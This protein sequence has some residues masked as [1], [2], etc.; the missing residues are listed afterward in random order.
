[1]KRLVLALIPVLLLAQT[2]TEKLHKIFDEEHAE[3]LRENPQLAASMY[4]RQ[5]GPGRWNDQS[6]EARD[7]RREQSRA[8]LGALRALNP[9][10]LSRADRFNY[11]LLVNRLQEQVDF[12]A[13]P[14][15]LLALT[16]RFASP[17]YYLPRALNDSPSETVDDYKKILD[18]LRGIPARLDQQTALLQRGVQEG[19]VLPDI[20]VRAVP[21]QL[22][23]LAAAEP[24][25]SPLL[26][27]FRRFPKSIPPTEQDRL[28]KEANAILDAQVVPALR[29]FR[30]Y[31]ADQN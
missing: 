21:S 18:L 26:A 27:V 9:D 17:A 8:R 31:V 20:A 6:M 3:F 2:D 30:A 15:D 11:D 23:T 4:G 12:A 13:F 28:A 25:R 14:A 16:N 19:I 7:R 5:P 24:A 10:S 22:D 1:M 29:K